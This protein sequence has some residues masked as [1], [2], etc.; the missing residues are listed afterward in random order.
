MKNLSIIW[1]IVLF[2]MFISSHSHAATYFNYHTDLLEQG[3]TGGWTNSL[4]TFD[5]EYTVNVGKTSKID[6]WVHDVVIAE[7]G[8]LYADLG[9]E[10]NPFE[11]EICGVEVFDG[12]NGLPGPW[13][14]L[15][16]HNRPHL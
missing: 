6:V 16:H 8:I 10:Y 2:V 1:G 15:H 9:I 5:D 7:D 4:K 14:R 12:V 13:I 3:N 11:V